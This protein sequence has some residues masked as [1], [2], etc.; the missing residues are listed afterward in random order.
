MMQ[1]TEMQQEMTTNFNYDSFMDFI[2]RSRVDSTLAYIVYMMATVITSGAV[3][4]I[5][6]QVYL[7][8]NVTISDAYLLAGKR[9]IT[10][11]ISVILASLFGSLFTLFCVIGLLIPACRFS[12]LPQI[13]MLEKLG[14][15]G[16]VKRCW[17]ITAG[18][19]W[20]FGTLLTMLSAVELVL[21]QALSNPLILMQ[22]YLATHIFTSMSVW[23]ASET[24]IAQNI[25][26]C[27][28]NL[29]IQPLG[30]AVMT[31]AYYDIRIR[32][33]GFDM[34]II[35]ELLDHGSSDNVGAIPTSKVRRSKPA[36]VK[37]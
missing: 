2:Y 4:Y 10:L 26:E 32:N 14:V 11:F 8:R 17:N 7:G 3:G 30:I 19:F 29:L 23:S 28:V 35:N 13:I 9:I 21:N 12:I 1:L 37:R 25:I 27:I 15:V 36:A 24:L 6:G 5:V 22:S 20:R 33:E 34:A 31:V 18:T 16:S